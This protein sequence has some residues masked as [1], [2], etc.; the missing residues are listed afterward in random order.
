MSEKNTVTLAGIVESMSE[1]SKSTERPISQKE[2]YNAVKL[3]KLSI[4]EALKKGQKVQLTSFVSFVPTY[5]AAR[6][7]NNV[8]TKEPL[9]IPAG[10]IIAAKAGSAVKATSKDIPEERIQTLKEI[11]LRKRQQPVI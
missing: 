6:K 1:L 9:E 8:M 7:G 2:A 5:R 4:L 11:T 10:V 3:L